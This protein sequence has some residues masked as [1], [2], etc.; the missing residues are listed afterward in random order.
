MIWQAFS[1][2]SNSENHFLK[3]VPTYILAHTNTTL[4]NRY[5]LDTSVTTIFSYTGQ[6]KTNFQ[7]R[8]TILTPKLRAI[9]KHKQPSWTL[10]PRRATCSKDPKSAQIGYSVTLLQSRLRNVIAQCYGRPMA[11]TYSKCTRMIR[12]R[13]RSSLSLWTFVL[14]WSG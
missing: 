14:T 5:C 9:M 11:R 1:V 7:K 10:V 3:C 2:I 6:Q 12:R 8:F 13:I 4:S